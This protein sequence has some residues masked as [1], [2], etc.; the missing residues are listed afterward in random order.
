[1]DSSGKRVLS[2]GVSL[3]RSAS[4]TRSHPDCNRTRTFADRCP[5]GIHL[6][7][8]AVLSRLPVLVVWVSVM[9]QA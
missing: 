3:Q 9:Y 6:D 5:K 7:I 1:M 2:S 4:S 8:S